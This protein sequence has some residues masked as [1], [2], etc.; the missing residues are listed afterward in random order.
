MVTSL[1]FDFGI[2]SILLFVAYLLRTKIR[3]FQRLF[4]P[5]PLIAGILGILLGPHVLGTVS[6]VCL[7][8][9]E[10]IGQVS[11]PL[12]SCVF[13]T[14]LFM[15]KFSANETRKAFHSFALMS[16][17]VL[18]QVLI[19]I[20]LVRAFMPGANDAY[21]LLPMTSFLGGPG[22]C[23][24][25]TN[26][27]GELEN[28]SVETANSIGNTYATISMVTGVTIGMIMINIAKRKGILTQSGKMSD[29]P[30][31]EFTGFVPAG[32]R[33]PVGEDV[34]GG[35]SA[36]SMTLQ[37]SIAGLIIFLG[38]VAQKV[39]AHIPALSS[40]AITITII[41]IGLPVGIFFKATKWDRFVDMKSLK[42][43][44]SIALEYLIA[45]TIANTNI[46]VFATHG[47]LLAVTAV[48]VILV[49]VI[50]IMG[51]GKLWNR[52]HWFENTIGVFGV[53]NGVA[54]TGLL[55]LRTS[56]PNDASGALSPFCTGIAILVSTTQMI[57]IMFVPMWIT[58]HANPV[59]IGTGIAL[60]VF[61]ALGFLV[62]ARRGKQA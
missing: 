18:V 44:S 55:L 53:A 5:A 31:E 19:G 48:V 36:N 12:L 26:I 45:T 60:A 1:L 16:I 40:L 58:R 29:I 42:H 50:M 47:K 17:V 13:C 23:T 38:M 37:F 28:F 7:Q 30:K 22:V 57:Y 32:K 27:V 61:L 6:P 4:L 3:I 41:L 34:T 25:V 52:E 59:L 43:F 15:M 33:A 24:I 39:L 49:N 62:G 21:G 46:Q 14:Q 54:A 11:L 2:T 9:S 20:G 56:D 35:N 10:F 51:L 8:Y